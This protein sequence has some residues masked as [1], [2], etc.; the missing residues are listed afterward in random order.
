MRQMVPPSA[1]QRRAA[2]SARTS[3]TGRRSKV[4]RLMSLSTSAVAVCCSS[5]SR[6]SLMSRAFSIAITAWSAKVVTRAICFS[7]K[8]RTSFLKSE[9]VPTGTP[10]RMSGT[11]SG[12]CPGVFG[13]RPDIEDV[14]HPALR[15]RPADD[16]SAAAAGGV[17]L[18]E[19]AVLPRMAVEAHLS[20]DVA[21]RSPDSSDLGATEPRGALGE[22]VEHGLKVE[23]RA[24]NQL[25]HVRRRGLLVQ[26]LARLADEPRVLD[27]DHRLV[28]EGRDQ[29]D[30]ILGERL[31]PLARETEHADG[32]ALAHQRNTEQGP[33]FRDRE[34]FRELV[35]RVGGDV[36]DLHGPAFLDDASGD[37]PA[38]R[39]CDGVSVQEPFLESE[40]VGR[41]FR[42][43]TDRCHVTEY[44]A[45][46]TRDES[47]LCRAEPAR[48][49]GDRRQHRLY[50]E[51]LAAD[52][53]QDIAGRS[54]ALQRLRQ[55][56][57]KRDNF[58]FRI[59]RRLRRPPDRS[60]LSQS[61]LTFRHGH[62]PDRREVVHALPVGRTER[63]SFATST[64]PPR[65]LAPLSNST[66]RL[67]H[68][69]TG[70]PYGGVGLR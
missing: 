65:G 32:L 34:C 16:G 13:I 41:G 52:D 59:G 27:C 67:S 42:G 66:L 20:K 61:L 60:R 43:G 51:G 21:V 23:G 39:G 2:L 6:V 10:S 11:P 53:L 57:F 30:L 38:S 19:P 44:V 54:L 63:A 68:V 26:R 36:G 15:E 3:S 55:L 29:R 24:A 56:A 18:G 45:V 8:A 62:S 12:V 7:V 40:G 33:R 69:S 28:R 48:R 1:P 58:L 46:A 9:N 14:D 25:E 35:F 47:H 31:D 22:G 5:A 37:G 49:F 4:E 64:P 50:V 70:P 17:L